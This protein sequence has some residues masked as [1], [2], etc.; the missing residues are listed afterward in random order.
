MLMDQCE[1]EQLDYGQDPDSEG[2]SNFITSNNR[3]YGRPLGE[4]DQI[5]AMP[6]PYTDKSGGGAKMTAAQ[7]EAMQL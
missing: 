2:M 6:L 7:V 5:A 3:P 4:S 1:A